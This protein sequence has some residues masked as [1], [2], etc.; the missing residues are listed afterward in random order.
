MKE[1]WA[2]IPAEIQACDRLVLYVETADFPLKG[3]FVE[4]GMALAMHKPVCIV[5]PDL[6]SQLVLDMVGSW[7]A[8]PLVSMVGTLE[9]AFSNGLAR[10]G[11][12]P[13]RRE[14]RRI[15]EQ[16]PL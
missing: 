5:S 7:R 16:R 8:H 15:P 12:T 10:S 13:N 3:A 2:R 9:E 1:L 4:V 6:P 14:R 11:P